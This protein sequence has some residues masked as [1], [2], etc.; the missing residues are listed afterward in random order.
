MGR[1]RPS[2]ERDVPGREIVGLRVHRKP[3]IR[4]VVRPDDA[5]VRR[6]ADREVQAAVGAEPRLVD[7][8]VAKSGQAGDDVVERAVGVEPRDGV[9]VRDVE[10]AFV[11]S[12]SRDRARPVPAI[13]GPREDDLLAARRWIDADDPR[14]RPDLVPALDHV[15]H[16]GVVEAARNRRVQP[17]RDDVDGEPGR[18]EDVA[19]LVLSRS[20]APIWDPLE[21]RHERLGELRE[22]RG[23]VDRGRRRE[24]RS[25]GHLGHRG[26]QGQ[27][28]WRLLGREMPSDCGGDRAGRIAYLRGGAGL[29]GCA[30]LR[31][32]H[33]RL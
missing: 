3:F 24:L 32:R 5:R 20:V 22:H 11:P 17:R 33:G 12:R 9:G 14:R 13:V 15:R 6:R 25:G 8:V 30:R 31:R 4:G 23:Q 21:E 1:E 10:P 2:D 26:R 28:V 18:H 19:R 7:L 29:R 27:L 16:P